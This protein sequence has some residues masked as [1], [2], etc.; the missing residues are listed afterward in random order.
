MRA[1]RGL[2]E[3]YERFLQG[4]P[5]LLTADEQEAIRNLRHVVHWLTNPSPRWQSWWK[6]SRVKTMSQ[7]DSR[8]APQTSWL[9]QTSPETSVSGYF[10]AVNPFAGENQR[11]REF[12]VK[13]AVS[14]PDPCG[15]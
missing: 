13:T 2:H 5:K 3:E 4:Q 6:S 14:W 15:S 7:A 9:R 1:A 8:F 10:L 11:D 12:S